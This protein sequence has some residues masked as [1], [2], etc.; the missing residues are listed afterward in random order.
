MERISLTDDVEL[1]LLVYGMWRLGNDADTSPD[2][3]RDKIAACL[4]QGITTMDQADIYGGYEAEEV[5]GRALT[6]EIRNRIEIVTKCDIVAP[7]GRHAGALVKHYDTSRAHIEASVDASLRLMGIEHIDLLLVH[8]PDPFMDHFETGETLD[9]LVKGGKVR[10]VGA[11][12]FR[13]WDWELL[14][15]GMKTPLVTNQI[16]ISLLHHAPFTNGDV[17]FHQ[18][19]GEPLMAW[20]PLGGGTLFQQANA[21]LRRK[22]AE[23]G[24]RHGVDEAA[25]AVAW[26]LAHPARILPVLGTNNLERIRA[27]GDAV[28]VDL[29]RETWFDLYTEALGHEVA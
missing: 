14:Q 29:G 8:R 3:V 24:A 11:S 18:K 12:N 5:L 4:D 19:N 2:R 28:K 6:P 1:S 13:R 7:A 27:I 16:E 23:V 26:L 25:V 20:S 9:N 17:A 21:G 22:L 10:A 15:S